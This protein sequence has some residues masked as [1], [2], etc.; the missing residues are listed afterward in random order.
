[1]AC[2]EGQ[3]ARGF[4]VIGP[5]PI[6]RGRHSRARI[7]VCHATRDFR[8]RIA[9]AHRERQLRRSLAG[10]K[11]RRAPRAIKVVYRKTCET[12]RP[13][14]REFSGIKRFEPISRTHESLID[15]LHVGRND[16]A[17]HF[18]YVMEPADD[19]VTIPNDE[20]QNPKEARIQNAET[21]S[22][23]NEIRASGFLRHSRF[24]IRICTCRLLS[25]TTCNSGVG[26]RWKNA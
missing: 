8:L 4:D 14:E 21:D 18:Y 23:K 13:Y 3:R 12:G 17:G 1:M 7:P 11:C 20:G 5:R 6:R 26:C 25:S 16:D 2:H 15:V 10:A 22:R 9:P 19:A 24:V